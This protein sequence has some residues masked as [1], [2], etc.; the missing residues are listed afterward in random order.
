[1]KY[2][3]LL[4]FF[5][6]YAFAASGPSPTY[7]EAEVYYQHHGYGGGGVGMATHPGG[8]GPSGPGG[9]GPGQLQS[10]NYPA[11]SV[12]PISKAQTVQPT[13][14]P[15]LGAGSGF[16]EINK[17]IFEHGEK[18]PKIIKMWA[19][20][21]GRPDTPPARPSTPEDAIQ[22]SYPEV[23]AMG[24]VKGI[25]SSIVSVEIARKAYLDHVKTPY[26]LV[27]Q[28]TLPKAIRVRSMVARG[29]Q[30]YKIGTRTESNTGEQSQFWS[31]EN[32]IT[33]K[34][35]RS[36][37]S[38]PREN[39]ERADFVEIGKVREGTTFITRPAAPKFG[40][41]GGGIEIVVPENSVI[42]EGH[43]SL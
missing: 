34:H 35:Y 41:K 15:P 32:P 6:F 5:S 22:P 33:A 16:A 40:G 23:V 9:Y 8:G 37:Y 10:H 14:T 36:R 2:L 3:V 1:M 7:A 28:S 38:V 20:A 42:V 19:K 43:I 25:K 18:N 4:M 27:F 24:V 12:G 17:I 31:I 39:L 13:K 26:G 30:I 11:G 21:L 29:K